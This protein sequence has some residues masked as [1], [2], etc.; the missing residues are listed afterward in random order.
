MALV[1]GTNSGFVTTA[2]TSDP[3]GPATFID[4][5]AIVTADTSPSGAVKIVEIGW[6]CNSATEES[7]FEVGLYA[8]DGAVVPDEAGT[9]LEVSRTHA[10]GTGAGWKVVSGLDWNISASTDYWLGVQL[11]DTA[12]GTTTDGGGSGGM[13]RDDLISQSTLP[14]PFNGGTFTATELTA[15]YAVTEEAPAVT[16][17]DNM[18][19]IGENVY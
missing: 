8:A 2:P 1:L 11:D 19:I 14:D 18:N 17:S 12:T 3:D 16:A 6:W 4:D 10:K 13:G 5:K 9:L 7:N 15:I